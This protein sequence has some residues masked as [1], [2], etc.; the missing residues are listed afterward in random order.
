MMVA[1]DERTKATRQQS[2]SGERGGTPHQS[3]AADE[4]VYSGGGL[5]PAGDAEEVTKGGG[6]DKAKD[7][8]GKPKKSGKGRAKQKKNSG[9][10][11]ER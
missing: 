9:A 2:E 3:K 1:K 8:A 10:V 5:D 6:P 4:A 11:T 7:A